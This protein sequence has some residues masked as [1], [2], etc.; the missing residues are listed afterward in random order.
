MHADTYPP[1]KILNYY[2]PS[3]DDSK[4]IALRGSKKGTTILLPGFAHVGGDDGPFGV[5]LS[6]GT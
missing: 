2:I 5:L 1:P 4:H 6:C 3:F